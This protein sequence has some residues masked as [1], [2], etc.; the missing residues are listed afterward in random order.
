MRG[1][2]IARCRGV[3]KEVDKS[4][5]ISKNR[6][7]QLDSQSMATKMPELRS[8]SGDVLQGGMNIKEWSTTC[9]TGKILLLILRVSQG[10]VGAVAPKKTPAKTTKKEKEE[11]KRT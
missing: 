5:G 4:P 9:W 2:G 3:F 8:V 11:R 10:S 7:E 6:L 1:Y